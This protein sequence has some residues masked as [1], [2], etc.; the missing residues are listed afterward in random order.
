MSFFGATLN[1]SAQEIYVGEGQIFNINQLKD[2][3]LSEVED[4]TAVGTW[5]NNDL[6]LLKNALKGNKEVNKR[7]KGAD[8]SKMILADDVTDGFSYLF[9]NCA[10]LEGISLPN[11]QF[12]N[13]VSLEGVFKSCKNLEVIL[14][15]QKFMKV[16]SFRSAF[17]D[18]GNLKF[19]FLPEGSDMAVDFDS[20][21][22]NC[23]SL[24]FI[25][26]YEMFEK[27][28]IHTF[29]GAK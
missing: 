29:E 27:S 1:L 19:L 13:P 15:L 8:F 24:S 18:C 2:G 25:H 11:V 3:V 22:Q 23:N 10:T 4:I 17:E 16:R 21:F 5:S 6:K 12:S 7:L 28:N 26:N 20:A 9:H 14:N